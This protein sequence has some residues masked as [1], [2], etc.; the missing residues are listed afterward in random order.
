MTLE[1]QPPTQ[2]PEKENDVAPLFIKLEKYKA[3]LEEINSLKSTLSG[4]KSSIELLK[5]LEKLREENI[6]VVESILSKL[7]RNIANLAADFKQPAGAIGHIN[8]VEDVQK[9]INSIAEIRGQIE[10]IK[11][12]NL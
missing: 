1:K 8:E 12:E 11:A 10:R 2:Q 6:K 3:I 5:D 4:L 7:D 9:L